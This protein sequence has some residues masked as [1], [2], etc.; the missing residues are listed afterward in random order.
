MARRS[1][2]HVRSE[3]SAVS[4]INMRIVH[5]GQIE[6]GID[7]LAEMYV[8]SAPIRMKR[9]ARYNTLPRFPQ[10]FLLTG[11]DAFPPRKDES[12]YSRIIFRDMPSA[13]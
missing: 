3:H 2:R 10:T 9:A 1:D 6:I 5:H 4:H 7:V 13:F 8:L 11:F 12:R